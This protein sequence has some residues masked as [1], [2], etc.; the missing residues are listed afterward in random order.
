MS[1]FK[2]DIF[3]KIEESNAQRPVELNT[4][5]LNE[6]YEQ[7]KRMLPLNTREEVELFNQHLEDEEFRAGFVSPY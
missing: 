7:V 6:K 5:E 2:A 3:E 1:K 4:R